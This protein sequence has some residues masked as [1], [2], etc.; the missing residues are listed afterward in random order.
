MLIQIQGRLGLRYVAAAFFLTATLSLFFWHRTDR[1]PRHAL[2]SEIKYVPSSYDWGKAR[3]F[4]PVEDMRS[5]PEG[6]PRRFPRIQAE[7]RKGQ[8]DDQARARKEIIKDAFVKSWKAYRKF[9]WAKDELK[10]ITGGGKTTFSGWSAQLVD[11]MDTL[12]IMGL[13]EDFNDAIQEVARIDWS[14]TRDRGRINL[15][16]V[17]I[18]YLGGLL[19]AYDLS[20]LPILR[21]K[22]V[23]LADTLYM[24]FDTPNRLPTHYLELKKAT[25]GETLADTK[26]STA[27]G[28]TL[29]LEFTRLSQITGDPKYYD[30]TERVKHFLYKWQNQTAHP[31]MWPEELN[32]RDENVIENRYTLSGGADSMYEYFPKMHALLG[33]LDPQY[34]E[35]TVR[36]LETARDLLLFRPMTPQD[37]NVL[38]SGSVI[39]FVGDDL[40]SP[41]MDHLTCFAGGMYAL[42]G[43][44]LARE[45]FV[46][47]GS[48]LTAGC[49]WEYDAMP[50]NIMPD[51]ASFVRCEKMDGPC[52]YNKTLDWVISLPGFTS[53]RN[54]GYLQRPE[55]IESVFYMWRITG[56]QVWRDAAWRMWEGI[57]RETETELAFA[58]ILDVTKPLVGGQ[59]DVMETFWLAETLKYFYL[60]FDDDSVIDLD[61]W[62]FNTEAH[63][64]KRPKTAVETSGRR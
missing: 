17:T 47:L 45:D 8:Q 18:R 2:L 13:T 49:I 43:R 22:A 15:F 37:S 26:I 3:I 35:M 16:E 44:L 36:S 34:E 14:K 28:G 59:L 46:D 64:F 1:S 30:A 6:V 32:F 40:F 12:W 10:P 60:I 50:T 52:P 27:A 55:A 23:E 7:H 31:G 61:E 21:D 4:H 63:P 5:P 11:A 54:R 56:N 33:G 19:A 24:A 20:G 48:R 58:S 42:A 41:D 62:V 39:S 53:L 57:A 38:L 25:S 51:S 9:A 29:C